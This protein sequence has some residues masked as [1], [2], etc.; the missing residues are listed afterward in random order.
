MIRGGLPAMQTVRR[1]LTRAARADAAR[2]PVTLV[3]QFDT[4]RLIPS[5][6]CRREDSVLVG[7]ADDDAHL[8]AI[9]ELD[10]ATNERLLAEQQLLPGIGIEE[11][12][13]GVPNASVINAASVTRTRWAAASTGPT[14]AP[15]TPRSR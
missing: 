11:L 13:F 15:G 1:L 8:Q 7:I 12:V 14:A 9:F 6:F 2:R 10:N 5:R 4:H 3:R